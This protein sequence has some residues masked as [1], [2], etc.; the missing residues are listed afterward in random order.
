MGQGQGEKSALYADAP[1]MHA[2]ILQDTASIGQVIAQGDAERVT[3]DGDGEATAVGMVDDAQ[4][5]AAIDSAEAD[6]TSDVSGEQPVDSTHLGVMEMKTMLRMLNL[7]KRR[8]RSRS[9][10]T[11]TSTAW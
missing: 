5:A 10:S 6:H 8:A 9:W 2:E 3:K 4:A 1:T 7:P 11:R